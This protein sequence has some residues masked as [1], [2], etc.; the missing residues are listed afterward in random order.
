MKPVADDI[1]VLETDAGELIED[2]ENRL[3]QK[4]F[5]YFLAII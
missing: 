2:F 3:T 1:Q 5:G 4:L